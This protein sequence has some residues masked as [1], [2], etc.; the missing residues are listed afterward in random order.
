MAKPK[1]AAAARNPRGESDR[2]CAARL[3]S[4]D[5]V[6]AGKAAQDA[7]A[8]RRGDSA[9]TVTSTTTEPEIKRR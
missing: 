9:V 8:K 7:A 3:K 1:T 5:Q 6:R 2:V 4:A